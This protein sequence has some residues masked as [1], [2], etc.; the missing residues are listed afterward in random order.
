MQTVVKMLYNA[1]EKYSDMPYVSQKAVDEHQWLDAGQMLDG[2]G[3]AETTPGPLI[4]V[5]QFV[6]FLGGWK[7]HQTRTGY[8]HASR[9]GAAK[10]YSG[11]SKTPGPRSPY[12]LRGRR[13]P[14][15]D[16]RGQIAGSDIFLIP[17]GTSGI[18]LYWAGP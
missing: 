11:V 7:I 4:M 13:R 14:D 8:Q 10:F 1:A 5:V 17:A 16:W 15:R 9:S 3:L 2:L 18:G 12:Q 6:G